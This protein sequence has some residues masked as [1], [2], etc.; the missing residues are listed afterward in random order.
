MM[1]EVLLVMLNKAYFRNI[2]EIWMIKVKKGTKVKSISTL[3]L[4]HTTSS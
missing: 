1:S 2:H 4:T 3:D